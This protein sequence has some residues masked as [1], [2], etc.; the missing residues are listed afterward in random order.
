MSSATQFPAS[1]Q[2]P[3]AGWPPAGTGYGQRGMSP[4]QGR[5]VKRARAG[6]IVLVSMISALV[7][8]GAGAN[9]SVTD[10]V[11]RH[12]IDTSDKFLVRLLYS[13][14]TYQWRFSAKG[15]DDRDHVLRGQ[16]VLIAVVVV[17]TGLLVLAVCRGVVTFGRVFFGTWLAV[18][19]ATQLGA[20]ARGF[21]VNRQFFGGA[22]T[23]RAVFALFGQLSPTG[24]TFWGGVG[25]GLLVALV[26]ALAAVISRRRAGVLVAAD[27]E[28]PSYGG[29]GE[30][31]AEAE[32]TR[33]FAPVPQAEQRDERPRFDTPARQPDVAPTEWSTPNPSTAGAGAATG[34]SFD[35]PRSGGERVDRPTRESIDEP[36]QAFS[37]ADRG[38][39]LDDEHHQPPARERSDRDFDDDGEHTAQ[40]RPFTDDPPPGATASRPTTAESPA[41]SSAPGSSAPD[42]SAPDESAAER[43]QV[44]PPVRDEPTR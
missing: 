1:T 15:G 43:T 39:A 36:T 41:G 8:I 34:L 44:L 5:V 27:S 23:S 26:T 20:V 9:Q 3:A 29:Q 40:F 31:P 37:S 24:S 4:P 14:L 7:F 21:V 19:V 33:Q 2:Q 38:R 11:L 18:I 35:K 6:L 12:T 28:P 13:G 42:E 10:Y 32:M 30:Y 22:G 17:V 25:L 16:F